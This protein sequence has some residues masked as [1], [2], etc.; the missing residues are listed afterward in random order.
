MTIELTHVLGSY[1]R[2]AFLQAVLDVLL[3]IP[4]VIPQTADEVVERL[5]EPIA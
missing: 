3:L 5:L 2:L 4:F 1:F